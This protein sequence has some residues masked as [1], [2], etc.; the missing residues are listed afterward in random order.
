M[1]LERFLAWTAPAV[2][3][4]EVER[5]KRVYSEKII[6]KGFVYRIR[7]K[8][9]RNQLSSSSGIEHSCWAGGKEGSK[10]WN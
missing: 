4:Q 8:E 7:R 1:M 6:G 2:G 9:D 10:A 5:D 3:L